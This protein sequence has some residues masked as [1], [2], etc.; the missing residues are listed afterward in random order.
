M[1]AMN[2]FTKNSTIQEEKVTLQNLKQM[3]LSQEYSEEISVKCIEDNFSCILI[4]DNEIQEDM[5]KAI[6]TQIPTVYE[7][8]RD[9]NRLEF[10]TLELE[11]LQSFKIVFEYKCNKAQRCSELIVETEEKTYIFNDMY[12]TPQ[13][14]E[15]INDID[16]YFDEK[17]REVKDAF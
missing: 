7:Y 1:F 10:P 15:Y 8:S 14:I 6:F 9:L 5:I 12:K 16:E 17:I 3:L 13:T 2:S 4:K 11:Q